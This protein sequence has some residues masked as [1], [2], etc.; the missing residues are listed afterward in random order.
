METSRAEY[1]K[2][3]Q[4]AVYTPDAHLG[5]GWRVWRDMARELIQS[6]ELMWRLF[7]RDLSARYRQSVF[8]YVWAVMPAI[9]TV[10]TFTYL[11]GSGTLPI[12]E[13]NM[14]YPAY[15]LLGMSVWQLFA[16]GL[17]RTTQSLVQASA[18]ITK[19]NFAREAL[20]LAAFG[21]SIFDFLIRIVLIGVVFAW[22]GVVP[23]WTIIFVPFVLIPL[24]LMT[25]GFGFML[26][27][28]NGVFR[29][30]GNSLM[31]LLTF[32]MFLT[33]VIY[34]PPTQWPKVLINYLN[35]VSPFIIAT[36]DLTTVGTLSQL[37]G[38]F[39]ASVAGFVV[40]L[41][42]WRIFHLAM[43]RIAERV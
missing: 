36:R 25:V 23:V 9:V 7:L 20:V 16:T 10:V 41:V 38:L 24:A 19:I 32:A 3:T 22:Y 43:S 37:D 34:P 18:I 8:G 21:E 2:H 31:I 6:R 28:A 33:P 15:V 11:K 5:F 30:I 39:Y 27:I 17:T 12:G 13:T 4:E 40:F 1:T 14:P 29:D 42:A 35:P 26:S